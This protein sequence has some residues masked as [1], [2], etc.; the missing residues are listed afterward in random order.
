MAEGEKF[1]CQTECEG[2]H[3]VYRDGHGVDV[4]GE[5]RIGGSAKNAGDICEDTF[6]NESNCGCDIVGIFGKIGKSV[7]IS[8]LF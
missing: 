7:A 5:L 8:G 6:G 2:K 1:L 3:C 4:D